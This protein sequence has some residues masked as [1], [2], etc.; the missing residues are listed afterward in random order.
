MEKTTHKN[1]LARSYYLDI[2][3]N[4]IYEASSKP[5]TAKKKGP[6]LCT[7]AEVVT[8]HYPYNDFTCEEFTDHLHQCVQTP[9]DCTVKP[10]EETFLCESCGVGKCWDCRV[11]STNR[12]VQINLKADRSQAKVHTGPVSLPATDNMDSEAD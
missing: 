2:G 12:V 7:N 4:P 6:Q 1:N 3:L 11:Q 8:W 10:E 5:E 9:L